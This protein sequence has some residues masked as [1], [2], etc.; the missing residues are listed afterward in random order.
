MNIWETLIFAA[1]VLVIFYVSVHIYGSRPFNLFASHGIPGPKPHMFVGNLD[2][3]SKPRFLAEQEWYHKYGKILGYYF[4]RTPNLMVADREMLKYIMSTNFANF[5]NRPFVVPTDDFTELF[6]MNA[7]DDKWKFLRSLMMAAFSNKKLRDNS[8]LI[9]RCVQQLLDNLAKIA[10]NKNDFPANHYFSSYTMDVIA[11]T[12]FGI[13]VNSQNNPRHPFAVHAKKLFKAGVLQYLIGITFVF[14]FLWPWVKAYVILTGARKHRDFFAKVC[15]DTI[16]FRR[17]NPEIVPA[18]DILQTM[19]EAQKNCEREKTSGEKVLGDKQII[20]QSTM[21]LLAAYENT[22]NTLAFLSYN[23]ALHQD[24]QDKV[25]QEIRTAIGKE[26]ATFENIQ[27]LKY[28]DMCLSETL[29]IYPVSP[30]TDRTVTEEIEILGWTIPKNVNLII[31]I[32]SIHHDPDIWPNPEK[33]DPERFSKE[34]SA[35]HLPYSYLPFGS[36]PRM[37]MGTRF[38]QLEIKM[39]IVEILR[40][41]RLIPSTRTEVPVKLTE[42]YLLAPQNGIWLSVERR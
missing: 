42:Y 4:G 38:T 10:V 5:R 29:R 28:L 18:K 15:W 2:S 23:L 9:T 30:R 31:P 13:E 32:Y 37:C 1:I 41:Y 27:K 8:V 11:A 35:N 14:P 25:Y 21:F 6:L 33:F 22:A 12:G 20:A 40:N 34:N 36:G 7:K 24:I 19:L 17:Q 16:V 39:A 3:F 26:P